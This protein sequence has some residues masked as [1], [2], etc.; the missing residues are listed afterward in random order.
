MSAQKIPK[1]QNYD[2]PDSVSIRHEFAIFASM[3]LFYRMLKL[4]ELVTINLLF[5]KG[6]KIQDRWQKRLRQQSF[7][8]SHV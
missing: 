5:N 8:A 3:C 7:F 1:S 6:L 2:C 4:G